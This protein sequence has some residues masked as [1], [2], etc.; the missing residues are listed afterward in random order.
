MNEIT[1]GKSRYHLNGAMEAWCEEYFGPRAYSM[2]NLR[3][4]GEL[5]NLWYVQGM[6]GNTT[7]T[8]KHDRDATAFALRWA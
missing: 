3:D 5:K 4:N 8:F 6:F 1:F 2:D 7:F